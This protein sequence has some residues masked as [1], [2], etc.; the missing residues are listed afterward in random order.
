MV[1]LF[2]VLMGNKLY[3]NILQ[4]DSLPVTVP[5]DL[6]WNP[7]QINQIQFEAE[8]AIWPWI[9]ANGHDFHSAVKP[10]VFQ[11]GDSWVGEQGSSIGI[12]S[13]TS[14]YGSWSIPYLKKR[15]LWRYQSMD[16]GAE[17]RKNLQIEPLWDLGIGLDRVLKS[18]GGTNNPEP[19]ST[20]YTHQ[21]G[22]GIQLTGHWTSQFR[23]LS[24]IWLINHR[25]PGFVDQQIS[26][27]A[28]TL[29]GIPTPV[30]PGLGRTRRL[31]PPRTWDLYLAEALLRWEPKPWLNLHWGHSKNFI[32]HGYRSL[33]LSDASPAYTHLRIQAR[34]GPL[35][36]QYYVGKF[37]DFGS[38]L[39]PNTG[40][41]RNFSLRYP[42]KYS[43]M[44]YLDWNA[45]KR[46]QIGL[47]QA[48]VWPAQDSLGHGGWSWS[49][50][51]PLLFLIPAQF[52]TGSYGNALLGANIGYKLGKKAQL[53]GQLAVDE[54]FLKEFIRLSDFWANKYAVQIGGRGWNPMGIQG[55]RWLTELNVVR[56][57]M[58]SHWSTA[59]NYGHQQSALAHP[60]GANFREWVTR[61][62]Y[63]RGRWQF[64]ARY[65]ASL[66]GKQSQDTLNRGDQIN[67][68]YYKGLLQDGSYPIGSGTP[69]RL[70]QGEG[71]IA[72]LIYPPTRLM[73]DI[74]LMYRH[75]SA[76]GSWASGQY[77]QE[78]WWLGLGL[79]TAL[80]NEYRDF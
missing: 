39:I 47:F 28:V 14:D 32:G 50:A 29:Q 48:I 33:L 77:G 72:W 26:D 1:F 62:C 7:Q 57:F 11:A 61:A 70:L 69:V 78:S 12:P 45:N 51:Q 23:F 24:S 6:Q 5:K 65:S 38:P 63:F 43:A 68:N 55:L 17:L 18:P 34:W 37:L 59:T 15:P 54:I 80:F 76:N 71:H 3:A 40:P 21:N 73:V 67:Q 16:K 58:F 42:Q 36:Y 10:Y 79:R 74:T 66:Q 49:F 53:Y 22:R 35:L 13:Q 44:S 20:L 56:P 4:Q 2:L 30:L 75:R 64:S 19:S 46:L 25:V 52:Q 27:A 9:L 31:G 60:L 8:S 41:E